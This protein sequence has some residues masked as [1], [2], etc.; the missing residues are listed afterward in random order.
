MEKMKIF[1]NVEIKNFITIVTMFVFIGINIFG[2]INGKFDVVFDFDTKVI[3]MVVSFF[4]GTKV[5]KTVP[6]TTSF[7]EPEIIHIAEDSDIDE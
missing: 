1:E 5:A 6:A 7:L 3:L 4:L 2:C